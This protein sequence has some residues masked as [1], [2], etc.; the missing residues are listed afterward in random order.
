MCYVFACHTMLFCYVSVLLQQHKRCT[1]NAEPFEIRVQGATEKSC[2]N[3]AATSLAFKHFCAVGCFCTF[4]IVQKLH[5]LVLLSSLTCHLFFFCY[6][7]NVQEMFFFF[8]SIY[9][10]TC[11]AP[12]ITV[13][14]LLGSGELK[15][16]QRVLGLADVAI[17]DIS[18]LPNL[19]FSS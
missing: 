17:H 6:F 4:A 10:T 16:P 8:F 15:G 18:F 13:W 12:G 9:F 7:L 19:V 14:A 5:T 1:E 2:R 11:Y 3:V